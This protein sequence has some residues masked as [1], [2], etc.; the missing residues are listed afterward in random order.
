MTDIAQRGIKLEV[1][2]NL[3]FSDGIQEVIIPND[4]T[5]IKDKM[6]VNVYIPSNRS[7]ASVESALN[8]LKEALNA[9]N[10]EV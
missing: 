3:Y 9:S 1:Y 6:Y 8:K 10:S 4:S 7:L 5:I 2:Y